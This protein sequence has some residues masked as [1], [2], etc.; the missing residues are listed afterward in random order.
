MARS[1]QL[2]STLLVFLVGISNIILS[3]IWI[4]LITL[5]H[6]FISLASLVGCSPNT[7][8]SIDVYICVA[9]GRVVLRGD[10][11]YYSILQ[12]YYSCDKFNRMYL[13]VTN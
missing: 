10:T 5:L 7:A 8:V 9:K 3:Y 11:A 1:D 13:N 12:Q 2:N 4:L 6:R